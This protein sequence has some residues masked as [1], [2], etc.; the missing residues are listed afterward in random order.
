MA[1]PWVDQADEGGYT[2]EEEEKKEEEGA[3]GNALGGFMFGNVDK[4]LRLE[5]NYLDQVGGL[6][7]FTALQLLF[8]LLGTC[9]MQFLLQ[10]AGYVRT[11][12][13]TFL[14]RLPVHSAGDYGS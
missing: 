11:T 1:N 10:G 9:S 5:E 8:H 14:T 12:L 4:N 3:R 6:F 7:L 13:S 2:D